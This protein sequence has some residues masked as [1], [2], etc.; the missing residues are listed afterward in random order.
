MKIRNIII[1]IAVLC[2]AALGLSACHLDDSSGQGSVKINFNN[3]NVRYAVSDTEKNEM[4][5]T[6]TLTSPGKT[7]V[8]KITEKGAASVTISVPEGVWDIDVQAEG[9]RILGSGKGNV[10]VIA[11]KPASESISMNITGMRVYDWDDLVKV[12]EDTTLKD[13]FVEI[14]SNGEIFNAIKNLELKSARNITI[15]AKNDVTIKR[16]INF[17]TAP[18]FTLSNKDGKN[19]LFLDGSKGGKIVIQGNNDDNCRNSLINIEGNCE[20]TI[21]DGVTITGNKSIS[22]TFGG[23]YGGGVYVY[24]NGIFYM[25]GGIISGNTASN[26][27][28]GVYIQENGTFIKTGGVIYGSNEGSN[29]NTASNGNAVY[30]KNT[31]WDYTLNENQNWPRTP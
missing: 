5:Y 21:C 15:W 18:V 26:Q 24:N 1:L 29:S 11:G 22:G 8:T 28:G 27:G 7:P 12:F 30:D 16:D 4:I 23:G 20:L 3:S 14:I 31:P 2:I 9:K 19:T 17:N 10:T 6:I 13:I 25:E